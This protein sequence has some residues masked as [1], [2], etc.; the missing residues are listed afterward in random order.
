MRHIIIVQR[1]FRSCLIRLHFLE[2]RDATM[3]IQVPFDWMYHPMSKDKISLDMRKLSRF[4]LYFREAGENFMRRRT[5]LLQWSRLHGEVHSLDHLWRQK[6][7]IRHHKLDWDGTGNKYDICYTVIC[8]IFSRSCSLIKWL[9]HDSLTKKGLKRQQHVEVSPNRIQQSVPA[10]SRAAQRDRSKEK[11]EGRGSSTPLN[12]PLSLPLDPK[13]RIGDQ[14]GRP[15]RSYKEKQSDD[16]S[17]EVQR[18]AEIFK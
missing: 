10:C 8:S 14:S 6:I 2:R 5:E 15:V 3:I 16:S 12:R 18:R 13:F 1:W 4:I 11:F 9:S 7:K 17:P